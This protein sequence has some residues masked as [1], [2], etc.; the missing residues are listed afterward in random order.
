MKFKEF[1][2]R[3]AIEALG[4][5]ARDAYELELVLRDVR[6]F[7][8][9]RPGPGGGVEATSFS[10]AFFLIALMAGGARRKAIGTAWD[11][12]KAPVKRV[13]LAGFGKDHMGVLPHCPLTGM[14]AFGHALE[15]ILGNPDLADRVDE[16]AI[17]RDWPEARIT[18]QQGQEQTRFFSDA[19][20]K[21]T[22]R[23]RGPGAIQTFCT[24]GGPPLHQMAIDLVDLPGDDEG[25]P[26]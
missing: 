6:G 22:S 10:I 19:V 24:L 4:L 21:A 3:F 13:E 8:R 17:I 23:N 2:D 26:E 15:R 16:I 18:Y 25:T 1:Y 7:A 20:K 9:G 5:T 12:Y 11:Y 14:F